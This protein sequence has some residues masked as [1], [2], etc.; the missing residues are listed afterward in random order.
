VGR[1][2]VDGLQPAGAVVAVL[3]AFTALSHLWP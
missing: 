1:R 3:V 2:P